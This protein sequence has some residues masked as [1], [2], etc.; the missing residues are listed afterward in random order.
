MT[1]QTTPITPRAAFDF[2][3]PALSEAATILTQPP[4]PEGYD[5]AFQNSAAAGAV[6]IQAKPH[7][8]Q[9]SR[10][11]DAL[12]G[13]RRAAYEAT[14]ALFTA[15]ADGG[16]EPISPERSKVLADDLFAA[17][18]ELRHARHALPEAPQQR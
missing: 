5:D 7:V 8:E 9:P 2:S 13:A 18:N 1:M 14:S 15:R 3:A 4:T 16:F 17:A 6:L 10:A 12:Q 11:F